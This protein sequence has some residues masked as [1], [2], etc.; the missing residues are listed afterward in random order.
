MLSCAQHLYI[1]I[2]LRNYV[3]TMQRKSIIYERLI[4]HIPLSRNAQIL[5]QGLKSQLMDC[6]PKNFRLTFEVF[7]SIVEGVLLCARQRISIQAHQ[8]DRVYFS[9]PALRN[10]GN[11]IAILRL[12]AK[13]KSVLHEHLT[14]GPKN[15]K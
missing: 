15:A 14:S 12:L 13:N 3:K 10:E 7:P 4:V 1:T 9:V 11:S 5:L 8:Q 6:N 2:Y